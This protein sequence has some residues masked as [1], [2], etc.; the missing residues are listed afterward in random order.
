MKIIHRV[1]LG[2]LLSMAHAE[3]YGTEPYAV[4]ETASSFEETLEGVR[5]AIEERG[6]YINNVM[7]IGAMLDR[8][9]Q[10]LDL[11]KSPY[12]Q[13]KTIQFCSAVLSGR[14][15][16]EDPRRIVHCPFSIAVY[17]IQKQPETTFIAYRAF[18]SGQPAAGEVMKEAAK[19]MEDIVEAATAW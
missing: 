10:D 17:S 6:L 7:D 8:T 3:I 16:E 15:S 1:A 19:M 5:L 4:T 2:V 18:P 12:R 11:G 9:G 13:A 14:M